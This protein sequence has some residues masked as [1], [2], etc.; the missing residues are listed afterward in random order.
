MV[1]GSSARVQIG[2]A[3]P[4]KTLGDAGAAEMKEVTPWYQCGRQLVNGQ[5]SHSVQVQCPGGAW[6]GSGSTVLTLLESQFPHLSVECI[7]LFNL[8]GPSVV[9]I[10]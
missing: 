2:W 1:V 4:S 5:C 6:W 3:Q 8:W 10:P 7:R 9:Y